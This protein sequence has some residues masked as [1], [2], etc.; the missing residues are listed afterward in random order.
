MASKSSK[1]WVTQFCKWS[2]GFYC[3]GIR[4]S[5]CLTVW[6]R[7]VLEGEMRKIHYWRTPI[8]EFGRAVRL[9]LNHGKRCCTVEPEGLTAD[10]AE[11]RQLSQS[12][13]GGENNDLP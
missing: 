4:S 10:L 6:G 7:F 8:E 5:E 2:N 13:E 9:I 1:A 12:K 11:A 3:F